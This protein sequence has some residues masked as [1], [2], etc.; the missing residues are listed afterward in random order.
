MGTYVVGDIHGCYDQWMELKNIIESQDEAAVFILVGDIVDRGPKVMEMI[1]WAM[2]NVTEDGKYQMICGNHEREK[3][4]WYGEFLLYQQ[5]HPWVDYRIWREDH[6]DFLQNLKRSCVSSEE[7]AQIIGFFH[8]LPVFKDLYIDTGKKRGK[9]HYVVVHSYLPRTCVNQDETVKKRALQY[10]ASFEDLERLSKVEENR[11][12]VVWT[13]N[14]QGYSWLKSTIVLHGH[15]PTISETIFS[16]RS[17]RG[18]ICYRK[19]DINLDCGM[20]FQRENSNLAAVR[21]EDLQE[22]Y[23]IPLKEGAKDIPA[24][25]ARMEQRQ[26]RQKLLDMIHGKKRRA[27]DG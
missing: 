6:F 24:R 9:Q 12:Q 22:F 27:E 21:L 3:V 11:S 1:R 16:E 20:V 10:P 7:V 13:R 2:E 8:K 4:E 14:N 18:T 26:A 17:R 5:T 25:I 19:K 23:L 15:T